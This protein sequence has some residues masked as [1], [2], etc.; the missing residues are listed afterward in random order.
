MSRKVLGPLVLLLALAAGVWYFVLRPRDSALVLTGIVTAND[1]IVS[2]QIAGQLT[3]LQ[4]KEGDA[5]HRGQVLALI[6]PEELRA[7]SAFYAQSAQGLTSQ[8]QESE[9]ALRF[10]Q[11]Q[12]TD[13]IAQAE[14]MVAAADAQQKAAEADAEN[15]RLTF[16]RNQQL[17]K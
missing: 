12:T 6:A 14:A 16:E 5:V 17:V 15:A 9:A 4:V 13:Q 7:D 11:R 3:Q 8:V 1:V 2:S 10:Q